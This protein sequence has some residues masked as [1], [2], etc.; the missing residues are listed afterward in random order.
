MSLLVS[1]DFKDS[2][3]EGSSKS[4]MQSS[5]KQGYLIFSKSRKR[6]ELLLPP[7]LKSFNDVVV[8]Q[9]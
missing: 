3:N 9:R 5:S 4:K 8:V 2:E 1:K 7:L 6:W